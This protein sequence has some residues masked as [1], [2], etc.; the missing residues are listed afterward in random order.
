MSKAFVGYGYLIEPNKLS[1]EKY[2]ELINNKYF[3]TICGDMDPYFFG[4]V[5]GECDTGCFSTVQIVNR[6][7]VIE[8]AQ[9]FKYFYPHHPATDIRYYIINQEE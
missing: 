7:E 2:K 4:L 9:T 3:H 8:M 5:L 6:D 1:K